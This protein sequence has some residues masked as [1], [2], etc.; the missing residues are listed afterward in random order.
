MKGLIAYSFSMRNGGKGDQG[1]CN[2][3]LADAVKRIVQEEKEPVVIVVQGEI[4]QSMSIPIAKATRMESME[5]GK[6]LGSEG[7]T[8][9]AAEVFRSKGITEVIVVAQPFLHLTKCK[10]LVR[11]AGFTVIDKKIG[12]IGFDS[13][14][15]QWYC[16]SA[17]HLLIYAV[18]QVFKKLL[19]K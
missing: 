16:K 13:R 6:Y 19:K 4:A 14:S 12:W 15:D 7:A 10:S 8:T 18:R 9:V 2:A 11:D 17:L 1:P 5:P 3:R